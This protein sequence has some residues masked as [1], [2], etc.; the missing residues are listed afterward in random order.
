MP[1]SQSTSLYRDL[2]GGRSTQVEQLFG[3]LI[4]VAERVGVAAPLLGLTT[5][6]LRV[7]QARL[8]G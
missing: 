1:G 3:D 7:H 2:V 6:A 5:M 4:A 8:A